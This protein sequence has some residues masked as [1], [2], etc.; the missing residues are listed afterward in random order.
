M[1]YGLELASA[2]TTLQPHLEQASP[3]AAALPRAASPAAMQ[4]VPDREPNRFCNNTLCVY[5]MAETSPL[6]LC[7]T[8]LKQVAGHLFEDATGYHHSLVGWTAYGWQTYPWSA[9]LGCLV[10]DLSLAGGRLSD[11]S[12]TVMA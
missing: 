8:C 1:L 9:L 12:A 11:L 3:V 2:M 6:E 5:A 10:Q 7:A 4:V